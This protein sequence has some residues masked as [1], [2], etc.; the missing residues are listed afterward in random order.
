MINKVLS[1]LGIRPEE[2]PRVRWMVL[3]SIAFGLSKVTV[4]SAGNTLFVSTFGAAAFPFLYMASAV[5]MPLAVMA[6][7]QVEKRLPFGRYLTV[8]LGSVLALTVGL[9]LALVASGGTSTGSGR[10]LIFAIALLVEIVYT[11]GSIEFWGLAARL[12][13]VREAKRLTGLI[14]AGEV[15]AFAAGGLLIPTIVSRIGVVN[16]LVLTAAA[17]A[18]SLV[19][20]IAVTRSFAERL[21]GETT[22]KGSPSND[23]GERSERSSTVQDTRASYRRL[24]YAV[25]VFLIFAYYF[26]DN[27]FYERL[28]T[29]YQD[30][31]EMAA[32]VGI[33]FGVSSLFTFGARM[34]A[35]KLMVKLGLVFGL[36]IQPVLLAAATLALVAVGTLT[37]A[38][39]IGHPEGGQMVIFWIVMAIKMTERVTLDGFTRGGGM[40]M[41]QPLPA[42]ERGRVHAFRLGV[43]EA[44]GGGVAGALLWLLLSYLGLSAVPIGAVL[45]VLMIG[46]IGVNWI[47]RSAYLEAL[48]G[49]LSKRVLGGGELHIDRASIDLIEGK[50]ASDH[51]GEVLYA[52]ELIVEHEPERLPRL[53]PPLLEHPAPAVRRR[54][55]EMIARHEIDGG[56]AVHRLIAGDPEPAVRGDAVRTL[57]ALGEGEAFEEVVPYLQSDDRELARGAMAGLLESGSIEAI[58]AAGESFVAFQRSAEPAD[59]AFAARV[60]GEVG[61]GTF[62][63]PLLELLRDG[64]PEVRK[65]ALLACR[66]VSNPKL[67]PQ[68]I[69]NLT[70]PMSSPEAVLALRRAG[71]TA[72]PGLERAFERLGLAAGI[73]VQLARAAGG[74][75]GPNAEEFLWRQREHPDPEARHG[76]LAALASRRFRAGDRRQEVAACIRRETAAVAEACSFLT[77]TLIEEDRPDGDR[78]GQDS[79]SRGTADELLPAA[80]GY[81]VERCGERV[82]LL[83]S[84]IYPADSISRVRASLAQG[85]EQL[86]FAVELLDNLLDPDVKAEVL[87]LFEPLGPAER[88]ARLRGTLGQ[89]A[90]GAPNDDELSRLAA[91]ESDWSSPWT[92]ACALDL[93]AG[94]SD[95]EL[96]KQLEAGAKTTS[97]VVRETAEHHLARLKTGDVQA[98]SHPPTLARVLLL[99][100]VDIFA[101]TPDQHLAAVATVAVEVG[102][103]AGETFIHEGEEGHSMYVVVAGRVKAHSGEHTFGEFDPG[104][105]IGELAAID[106][107]K[108]SA[109]VTTLTAAR[110]LRIEREALKQILAERQEVTRGILRVLVQRL[111]QLG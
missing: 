65:A 61:L 58:M 99:R 108:R 2:W 31:D 23:A 97:G 55:L 51:P 39:A 13:D 86:A 40:V 10:W 47:A 7:G 53:V 82:L 64:E 36:M 34:I 56:D 62:Y 38:G 73:R 67:W 43:V 80:I 96:R 54:A 70:G 71:E 105:S 89:P 93:L 77:A 22:S 84:S 57:I 94:R 74:I 32:F 1:L 5:M 45:L 33:L 24:I 48:T 91:G 72:L 66:R 95:G 85:G 111:R 68:V 101:E 88:L 41:L 50:L 30:P 18:V 26:A 104:A 16:L 69:D 83:L 21:G 4:I 11:L 63:R 29:R 42:A 12:F 27:M 44:I 102:L 109:S 9:R 98:E 107:E 14:G 78:P 75:A 6:L 60:I 76:V 25:S 103:E 79:P 15:L 59:R 28:E 46:W 90:P 100:Q 8:I 52:A 49:A 106:A 17:V 20:Q 81:D 110:L 37:D 35:G 87:P 92:R 19:A 3:H